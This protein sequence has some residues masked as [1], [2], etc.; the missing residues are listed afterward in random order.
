[1]TMDKDLKK[2]LDVC[3]HDH[4]GSDDSRK[5]FRISTRVPQKKRKKSCSP[6]SLA[7]CVPDYIHELRVTDT[8]HPDSVSVT[9]QERHERT[10]LT[11]AIANFK[12]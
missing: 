2:Q 5:V 6:P 12:H 9:R 8:V 10:E 1:M 7:R 11:F 4:A 3:P